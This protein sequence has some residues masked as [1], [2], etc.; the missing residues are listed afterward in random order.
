MF[1]QQFITTNRFWHNCQDTVVRNERTEMDIKPSTL[2][3]GVESKDKQSKLKLKHKGYQKWYPFLFP[4]S[5]E[6]SN[7]G[8]RN[9]K[10]TKSRTAMI[11]SS[12]SSDGVP[13]MATSNGNV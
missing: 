11:P 4:R 6:A 5:C 13:A 10:L 3:A 8:L 7:L 2:C 1:T 9:T 12:S